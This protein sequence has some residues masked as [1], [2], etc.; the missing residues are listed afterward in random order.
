MTTATTVTPC[1][2]LFSENNK[3][4]FHEING[5]IALPVTAFVLDPVVAV[6][7]VEESEYDS[8]ESDDESEYD[9]EEETLN[10]LSQIVTHV[11]REP[12]E[13]EEEKED[14]ESDGEVFVLRRGEDSDEEEA[15][16]ED[17]DDEEEEESDDEDNDQAEV[18]AALASIAEYEDDK[19]QELADNLKKAK[20]LKDAKLIDDAEVRVNL[21]WTSM[22]LYIR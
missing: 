16:D 17:S 20:L 15:D 14:D 10:A 22:I 8:D 13:P 12:L 11:E 19:F 21:G 1:F 5:G 6:A 2:S 4:S 7:V 9:S 18:A 3:F